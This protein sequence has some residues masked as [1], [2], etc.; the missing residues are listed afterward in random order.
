MKKFLRVAKIVSV[1]A[2]ALFFAFC[3]TMA[4]I[5][6]YNT[7]K[8]RNEKKEKERIERLIISSQNAF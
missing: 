1:S 4:I 5:H 7:V 8:E 2:V 6:T 3:I